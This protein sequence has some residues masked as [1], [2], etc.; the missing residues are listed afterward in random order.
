MPL[1]SVVVPTYNRAYCL[2]RTLESALAQTH[3][4]L[5][6]IVVDD[7]STDGT[8]DLVEDLARRD[9]RVRYFHQENK[10]VSA[11]R[12]QGIALARGE[13]LALL[14]SDDVWMPWKLELQ[15]ACMARAPEVGMVWSDMEAIDVDGAVAHERYL[16]TMYS[17]YRWYPTNEALFAGSEALSLVAPRLR[18]HVGEARF[19]TGNIFS[20]MIMGNLVHTSTVLIRRDRLDRV[21]GFDVKLM[22]GEDYDF[23]LRTCKHGPVGYVDR[24]TIRYQLGLPDRITRP[25][26]RLGFA[27]HFLRTISREVAESRHRIHLP[28]PMIDAVFAEAHEW[29]AAVL[30]EEGDRA[31]ARK[32]LVQALRHE[33]FSARRAELL[34]LTML[35]PRQHESLRAS[36]RR[37][38]AL[39]QQRPS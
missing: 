38:K 35:S 4:D 26:L 34:V 11:A 5:E 24:T 19:W 28:K 22:P 12:N 20:Q 25:A 7:G 16:R 13:F 30:I 9:P 32:H 39:L 17:A 21:Q 23:H 10:N 1:V 6:L 33:P 15:L 2:G 3:A 36:Y 29:I 14:D 8:R 27:R 37:A 31:E 18:D